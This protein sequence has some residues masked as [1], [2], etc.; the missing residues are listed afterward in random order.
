MCL[1]NKGENYIERKKNIN[2]K[3]KII[4]KWDLNSYAKIWWL[5]CFKYES[6]TF[7]HILIAMK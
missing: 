5:N 1:L 2:F 4:I 3:N 6:P 7:K